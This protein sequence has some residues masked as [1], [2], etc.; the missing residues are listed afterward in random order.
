MEFERVTLNDIAH[1][2]GIS[3]T[4]VTRALNNKP[5]V[6]DDMRKLIIET[7]K[8]IGYKPNKTAQSL[9]RNEIVIG[10]LFS[11]EPKEFST[12]LERGI[13][14]GF[15]QLM[16]YKVRSI[17]LPYKNE[18][19]T[20]QI[21]KCLN[22]L[23]KKRVDG[24][25]FSPSR[26]YEEYMDIVKQIE[27]NGI[28]ILF[29]LNIIEGVKMA[30]SVGLNGVTTGKMAAQFLNISLQDRKNV[31]I[32]LSSKLQSIHRS[33][34]D[35]FEMEAQKH[36]MKI[37]GVFETFDDNDIAYHITKKVLGDYPELNGIYVT[38]NNSV[39]V[40]ECL[41]D[42]GRVNDIVVVGQ[43]LYP[44]LVEKLKSGSLNMTLFQDQE[45]EG[46][47]AVKMLFNYITDTEKKML[48][49]IMTPVIILTSNVDDY[50]DKY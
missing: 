40:C 36:N 17:L 50:A 38:S 30:G 43:D 13:I 41:E 3:M 29:L 39:G 23:L 46:R 37:M 11:E 7:A 26:K 21:N 14:D 8:E 5:K 44:G 47:L 15:N 34:M 45:E 16:D 6:S 25:V 22:E 24:I 9:A 4:T 2:L 1:K 48:K 31:A 28:P 42:I 10:V 19:C 27:D 18:I 32:F 49:K 35:G 20:D 12:Y 33:C